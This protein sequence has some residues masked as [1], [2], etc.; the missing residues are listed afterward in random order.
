MQ[1]ARGDTAAR[2]YEG[3]AITIM[4]V[5]SL[6]CEMLY[7][8]NRAAVPRLGGHADDHIKKWR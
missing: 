7:S 1:W 2:R 8:S 3:P 5:T 6:S 4:T